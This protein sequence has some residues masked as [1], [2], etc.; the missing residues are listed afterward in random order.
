M[1]R[2]LRELGWRRDEMAAAREASKRWFTRLAGGELA[3]R[4]RTW[5]W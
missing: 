1:G 2:A 4:V 3:T 5:G